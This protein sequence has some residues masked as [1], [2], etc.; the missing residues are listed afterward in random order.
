MQ[1]VGPYLEDRTSLTAAR[2]LAELEDYHRAATEAHREH[3][4]EPLSLPPVHTLSPA[5][6]AATA[7]LDR[8][9]ALTD[10]PV[11]NDGPVMGSDPLFGP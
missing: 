4:Q 7:V 11:L 8:D 6:Q 10:G 1:V 2:L 5:P 9:P 3:S